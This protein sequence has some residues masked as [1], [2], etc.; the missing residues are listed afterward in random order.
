LEARDPTLEDLRAAA[1]ALDALP[2]QT[3][4]AMERLA[5]ICVAHRI[6]S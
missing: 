4:A 5:A 2:T 3:D 1:D 6:G